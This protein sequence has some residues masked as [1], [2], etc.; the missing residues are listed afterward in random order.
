LGLDKDRDD[1]ALEVVDKLDD[2]GA[3][4][5]LSH[6][7]RHDEA[8]VVKKVVLLLLACSEAAAS[9]L[10]LDKDRGEL[11]SPPLSERLDE[12]VVKTVRELVSDSSLR[13]ASMKD[14]DAALERRN[15]RAKKPGGLDKKDRDEDGLGGGTSLSKGA[16]IRILP[17]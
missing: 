17:F 1:G 4:P 16:V 5:S 6:S 10:G 2:I 3:P 8:V 14:P 7:E 11:E 13:I 9:D 15:R 12:I